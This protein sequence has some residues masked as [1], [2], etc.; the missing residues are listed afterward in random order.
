MRGKILS[1][2]IAVLLFVPSAYAFEP[3]VVWV[4]RCINETHLLL[5]ST[6]L[7][8]NG[9]EI[10]SNQTILCQYGCDFRSLT[11]KEP[12]NPTSTETTTALIMYGVLFLI[13]SLAFIIGIGKFNRDENGEEQRSV[14]LLI[15][16]TIIFLALAFQTLAFEPVLGNTTFASLISVYAMLCWLLTIVSMIAVLI[17]LISILRGDVDE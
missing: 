9:Q 14:F 2:L 8:I 11:C 6:G 4:P 3:E 16:S 15:F 17:G 5:E 13:A 12:Y 10:I 7:F 1:V